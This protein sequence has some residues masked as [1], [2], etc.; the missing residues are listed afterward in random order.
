[1]T[2]FDFWIFTILMLLSTYLGV[3]SNASMVIL[4]NI[5][6]AVYAVG[7]GFGQA[8]C[9]LVGNNV[10]R[11]RILKAKGYVAIGM[12]LMQVI[13]M[14]FSLVFLFATDSVIG[15]Y[16]SE[17]ETIDC[18]R[19]TLRLI[20][21]GHMIE[22]V[23]ILFQGTIRGIG[24]QG[25]AFWANSLNYVVGVPLA[26]FFVFMLEP[27]NPLSG[28]FGLWLALYIAQ[29]GIGVYYSILLRD[30]SWRPLE[31]PTLKTPL[32][33]ALIEFLIPYYTI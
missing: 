9:T 24:V 19:S 25:R 15:I 31:K 12:I 3:V 16:T 1:M 4:Y 27:S 10:G 28:L 6:S 22:S 13:N 18:A 21:F 7:L 29:T 26:I 5:G 30:A 32:L 33:L 8:V 17:P 20:A 11:G 2:Y 23:Q 14:G